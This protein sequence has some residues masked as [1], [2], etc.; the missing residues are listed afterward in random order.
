MSDNGFFANMK[1]YFAH[2]A[3]TEPESQKRPRVKPPIPVSAFSQ[4]GPLLN[5]MNLSGKDIYEDYYLAQF[6]PNRENHSQ[7]QHHPAVP[8]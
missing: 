8:K 7:E 3:G 2:T 5:P 1:D 6:L 4:G